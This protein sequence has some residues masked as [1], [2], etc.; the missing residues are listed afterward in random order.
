MERWE[1]TTGS[2]EA[3]RD[4]GRLLGEFAVAGLVVLLN[5]DLGAESRHFVDF[6]VDSGFSVWQTLPVGPTRSDNSPYSTSSIHAGNPLLINLDYLVQR[7]WVDA[8]T[9]NS[10][11]ISDKD[12]LQA[13]RIAWNSYSQ[14][15]GD[16]ERAQMAEFH[17]YTDRN[18]QQT[19]NVKT[20]YQYFEVLFHY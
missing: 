6:L 16:Q 7:N 8:S 18:C 12:R 13:L 4:L 20:L 3:T 10:R 5:G 9:L 2:P 1:T 15:A 17:H 14:Q 11:S 19:I